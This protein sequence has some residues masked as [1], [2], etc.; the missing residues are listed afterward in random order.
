MKWLFNATISVFFMLGLSV[1]AGILI[2]VATKF[3]MF[4]WRLV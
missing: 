4:G 1:A 2:H 3:F